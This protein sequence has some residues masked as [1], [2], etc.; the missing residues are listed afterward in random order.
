VRTALAWLV[1]PAVLSA[2][3]VTPDT[4]PPCVDPYAPCADAGDG[5]DAMNAADAAD[6]SQ[7]EAPP[8]DA[9]VEE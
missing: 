7:P 9:P 2:C 3:T 8:S 6:A 1:V 4:F 5:G